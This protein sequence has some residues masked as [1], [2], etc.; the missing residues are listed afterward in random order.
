MWNMHEFLDKY[1]VVMASLLLKRHTWF[2]KSIESPTFTEQLDSIELEMPEITGE[3]YYEVKGTYPGGTIDP[4]FHVVRFIGW[5]KPTLIYHHGNNEQ[6]FNYGFG[7]KNTFKSVVMANKDRFDANII[8][9]RAPFHNDGMRRYLEKIGYLSE[10]TAMLS[11]SVKLV[12]QLVETL[13]TKG[14]G[15]VVVTGVSLGGWVTNLHRSWFN[16]ANAYVPM[17]AGA[18]LDELFLSSYYRKLASPLVSAHPE[19]LTKVLNFTTQF[20]SRKEHNVFPLLARYDRIIEYDR[21]KRCYGDMPIA[22]IDKGHITGALDSNV[23][24]SHILKIMNG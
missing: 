18:A 11:A 16:S 4:A 13:K 22:I 2:N 19:A 8:N 10:F 20:T 6:P 21:Q 12:Q 15:K 5:D 9:L 7:S 17:F 1:S 14:V 3:R 23:L 24:C